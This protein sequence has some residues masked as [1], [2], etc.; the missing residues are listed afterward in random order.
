MLWYKSW[1]ETR[2]PFLIGFCVLTVMAIGHVFEFRTVQSALPAAKALDL[3]Q[4]RGPIGDAIRRAIDV[5][6]DF[7]GFIWW[8]WFRQN[9]SQ[10]GTFFAILLGIGGQLGGS[11]SG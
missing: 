2:W 6:R 1:L 9:L 8:Q 3:S 5:E 4:A 10:T 7:R 11:K